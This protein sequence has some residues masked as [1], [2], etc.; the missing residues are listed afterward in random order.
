MLSRLSSA[1][2]RTFEVLR[3]RKKKKKEKKKILHVDYVIR[4]GARGFYSRLSRLRGCECAV[5]ACVGSRW[6]SW[7]CD[8]STDGLSQRGPVVTHSLHLRHPWHPFMLIFLSVRLCHIICLAG[9]SAR[10]T[11]CLSVERVCALTR[12]CLSPQDMYGSSFPPL[13]P[14]ISSLSVLKF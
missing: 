3:E 7:R 13:C 2:M 8:L 6:S 12:R 14:S 5:C 10:R 1:T 4:V 9:L 11:V